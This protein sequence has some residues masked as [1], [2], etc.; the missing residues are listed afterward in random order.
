MRDEAF[1]N[2]TEVYPRL[3]GLLAKQRAGARLNMVEL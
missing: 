1:C 3:G 2:G